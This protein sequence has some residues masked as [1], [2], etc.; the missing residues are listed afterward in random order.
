MKKLDL[1]DLVMTQEEK[2]KIYQDFSDKNGY[3]NV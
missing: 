2:M 3:F 1:T